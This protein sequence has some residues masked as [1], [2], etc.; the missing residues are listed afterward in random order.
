MPTEYRLVV[1]RP[2][3]EDGKDRERIYLKR[4]LAHAEQGLTDWIRD[5]ERYAAAGLAVWSG[6]IETRDVTPWVRVAAAV[7]VDWS[8]R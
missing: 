1:R 3:Y 2:E 8:S 4:D 5:M 7:P 6:H